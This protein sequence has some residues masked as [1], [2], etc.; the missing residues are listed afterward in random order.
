MKHNKN[1]KYA[2]CSSEICSFAK[3]IFYLQCINFPV[4]KNIKRYSIGYY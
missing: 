4:Y 2:K 1:L 3:N